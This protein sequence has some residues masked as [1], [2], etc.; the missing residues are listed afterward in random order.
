MNLTHIW[1]DIQVFSDDTENVKKF[2]FTKDDAAVESVLYKY[3]TYEK[4]T[5]ICCSTMSGCNVGCRFCG[6]GDTFNRLL[7]SD[8]IVSQPV[9]L[10]EHTGTDPQTID[11]LQIMFMSMGEPLLNMKNMIQSL[12]YLYHRYPKAALLISSIGPNVDYK[13]IY[14]ISVVIPTIGLQFSIHESTDE[15]RNKLIPFKNK[16]TLSEIAQHG[17]VWYGHTGRHPFFNYCVHNNNSTT[18]DVNRL[19]QL[20]DPNIWQATISVICERD[21]TMSVAHLRQKELTE[22][23]NDKMKAVGFNTRIFDPAGQDTIGGGCGQLWYYQ[24][25]VKEHPQYSRNS[26]GN[27]LPIIH[28][29]F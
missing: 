1:N 12:Q 14:D 9:H 28:T 5:V 8:E 7:T 19:K 18:D 26:V 23:F 22:A 10:L 6:A 17:L 21:E 20:F 27:S 16:L 24:K 29:P 4:R 3:P 11:R 13:P 15:Q 25:W 2:V